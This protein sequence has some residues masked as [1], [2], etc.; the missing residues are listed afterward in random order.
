MSCEHEWVVFSTALQRGALILE[1]MGC[2]AFGVV[3]D[4][5]SEGWGEAHD[6][7]SQP[8]RWQGNAC[9]KIIRQPG[10]VKRSYVEKDAQGNYRPAGYWRSLQE[11]AM[12]RGPSRN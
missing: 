2:H 8:Y 3:E 1:C 7:P 5:T 10:E 6:A 9:V 11:E 4:P 12:G